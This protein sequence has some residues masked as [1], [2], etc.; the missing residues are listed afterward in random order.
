MGSDGTQNSKEGAT[1]ALNRSSKRLQ[2]QESELV[3][4][5]SDIELVCNIMDSR[6]Q[7][8]AVMLRVL[9]QGCVLGRDMYQD[10]W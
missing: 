5:Y 8:A 1:F 9:R 7:R 10:Q 2:P 4:A 6:L 3:N